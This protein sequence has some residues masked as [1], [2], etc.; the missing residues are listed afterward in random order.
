MTVAS[1]AFLKVGVAVLVLC[2]GVGCTWGARERSRVVPPP[3]PAKALPPMGYTIQA[4]AFSQLSN[5]VRMTDALQSQGL[6]AYYFRHESGLYKVRFGVFG[7]RGMAR[8]R[9][10]ELAAAGILADFYIVAPDDYPFTVRGVAGEEQLRIE[11][12]K[13]AH[14][15]LG[16]PY[17]WGGDS[18]DEG[19]DCSGLTWAVYHMN[20]LNLPRHSRDQWGAGSLVVDGR[21]SRAD[22]VFFSNKGGGAISH[23]GI[24]VGDGKFIHAPGK[25]KH[26][27]VDS[28]SRAYFRR[29][30]MGARTYL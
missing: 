5:A 7:S 4:G 19:F 17:R 18:A 21:L 20:G 13:T 10:Q 28:L 25:G 3:P 23:V 24:Y 11:I 29:H 14:N 30:Y 6:D 8:A 27:R 12:V 16:I 1:R 15:F 9:A 26:I 22:L 2:L